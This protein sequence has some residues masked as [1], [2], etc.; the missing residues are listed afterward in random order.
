MWKQ[1]ISNHAPKLSSTH[2]NSEEYLQYI[3]GK[4]N[5][6]GMTVHKIYNKLFQF[7]NYKADI[8]GKAFLQLNL[9][10]VVDFWLLGP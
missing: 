10:R 3:L 7:R 2:I 9:E 6:K 8:A 4:L 1:K 5:I